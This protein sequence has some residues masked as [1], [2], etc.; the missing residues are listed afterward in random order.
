MIDKSEREHIIA[1]INRE[2]V[3]AIGCTEPIAVALCVAKA[4]ETLNQRPQKIQVLLSANILKNAMGVGIPGTDMI[5][6]P[7]AVALGALIGKSEYQLEV[8]KDSTPEAVEAGKKMIEAQAIQISL[9]ENIEE[10]LYIEVTC[11]AGEEKATAIISGGHTNFVYLSKNDSVLMDKRS[12]TSGE[13]EEESVELNLKKVYDFATTSPIEE[14]QF[15]LEARRLN[16]QAAERSFKGNYGHEL[17]KTL[18]SSDS[19][20]LIMGSNTFTHILSYT[21]AACDA[22]MAGAMIP[23]MSNSGSG[24]QGIAAT[25][26]VVVYAEDNHKSEEELTRAL[27]LSHLTAIYIKQSLGR[28]SA[29]CGCVV[30]ATGS[31]CGITYLMGGN[32]QQVSF[33]V[34]NMIANLTGM[35]CDGAK[36]SC[37]LKLTSGVSTAVLSAILAMEN[38]CVTSVEGIIE[39]NVDLS[40]RNLTKIGSQGMNETDKLVLDIMTHKHCD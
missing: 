1:L 25:L 37:A 21:S 30:A 36:P 32:Y 13:T 28:L 10:K 33:A 15:I 19:E 2:V 16:K 22:R 5:G 27:I 12:G 6:L 18:C 39:D 24:N 40:I 8:L 17:G 34:Q 3:P 29:L 9:K 23:V 20:R 4:A 14:L 7:I 26:P 38:K 11:M 31:S 35:I